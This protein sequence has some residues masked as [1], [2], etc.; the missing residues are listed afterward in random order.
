M[1]GILRVAVIEIDKDYVYS[2]FIIAFHKPSHSLFQVL[3]TGATKFNRIRRTR[4]YDNSMRDVPDLIE[5]ARMMIKAFRTGDLGKTF[6]DIDFL[7]YENVTRREKE[8]VLV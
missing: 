5:T 7:N 3:I 4:D 2:Y 8:N 6:L 1:C